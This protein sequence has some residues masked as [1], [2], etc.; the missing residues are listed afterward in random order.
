MLINGSFDRLGSPIIE[1][2]LTGV[3]ASKTY[4]ATIDTGFTGFV[5]LNL[6][7]MV[8]LNLSTLGATQVTLGDGS[9]VDDLVASGTLTIGDQTQM[10][11]ILLNETSHEVLVGLEFLRKFKIGMVITPSLVV[12]Y[13]ERSTKETAALLLQSPPGG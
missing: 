2:R 3:G 8:P 5:A 12:L 11:S 9:T 10:G 6:A 4:P 1:I 13:D 7:E